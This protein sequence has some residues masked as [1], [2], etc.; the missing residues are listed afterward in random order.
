MA[1]AATPEKISDVLPRT[2]AGHAVL[3]HDQQVK[4]I[5][6]WIA[7]ATAARQDY[8]DAGK[9]YA[10]YVTQEDEMEANRPFMVYEATCRIMEEQKMAATPAEKLAKIDAAYLDHLEAQRNVV[11]K[12]NDALTR[13]Q[14]ARLRAELAIAAIRS[15]AGMI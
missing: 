11:A 4:D 14:S 9:E 3:D 5:Q 15:I 8:D 1:T 12:K 2:E 6:G 13:M 10:L 7:D